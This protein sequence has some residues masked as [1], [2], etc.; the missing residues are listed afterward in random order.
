MGVAIMPALEGDYALDPLEIA[1]SYAVAESDVWV[2][3][4]DSTRRD[5]ELY[6]LGKPARG[7]VLDQDLGSGLHGCRRFDANG[8]ELAHI[9]GP[10][11]RREISLEVGKLL[12]QLERVVSVQSAPQEEQCITQMELRSSSAT[13]VAR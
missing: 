8:V 1:L 9:E 5:V 10:R 6:V 12:D 4:G 2:R 3:I 7:F 11:Q 13:C